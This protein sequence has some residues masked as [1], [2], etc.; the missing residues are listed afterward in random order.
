MLESLNCRSGGMVDAHDSKSCIVRC[1]SSSLSS[2]TIMKKHLTSKE[3]KS[4]YSKVPRICVEVLIQT[5]KGVLL[6]L[7]TLPSWN[8]M[9]HLPGGSVLYKETLEQ[10]VNR[11]SLNEIGVKANI[12]ELLGYIEY[13]SEEK[14]RGFGWSIG[15]VLL[16]KTKTTKFKPNKDASEIEF[17]SK[18]PER[19]VVEQKKFL[20]KYLLNTSK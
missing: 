9:W 17:F 13:P 4:I 7:R 1:E 19:M 18:L 20:K 6:S 8:N 5:P 15:I 11:V 2:G 14:E 10:A 16:C 12:I 3:F